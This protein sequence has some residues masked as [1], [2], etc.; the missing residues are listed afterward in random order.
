MQICRYFV[1]FWVITCDNDNIAWSH[2]TLAPTHLTDSSKNLLIELIASYLLQLLLTSV[3]SSA[4]VSF[5]LNNIVVVIGGLF[6]IYYLLSLFSIWRD[7]RSNLTFNPTLEGGFHTPLANWFEAIWAFH[8]DPR[9]VLEIKDA[10][11]F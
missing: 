1:Y 6:I 11:D 2:P 10:A 9:C 7:L 4:S 8:A 5:I 3:L